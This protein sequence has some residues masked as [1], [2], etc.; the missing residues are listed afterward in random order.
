[1]VTIDI[2]DNKGEKMRILSSEARLL[3]EIRDELKL[4]NSKLKDE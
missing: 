3:Q 4:L 1:M 2:I